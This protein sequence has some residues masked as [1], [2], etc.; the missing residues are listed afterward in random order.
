MYAVLPMIV[1][2]L[3]VY[4][5]W[6]LT[7]IMLAGTLVMGECTHCVS[8]KTTK[9]KLLYNNFSFAV[10]TKPKLRRIEIDT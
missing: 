7:G 4:S 9:W 5:S 6:V 10:F 3:A 2:G 1:P 8:V